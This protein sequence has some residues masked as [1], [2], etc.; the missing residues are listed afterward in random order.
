MKIRKKIVKIGRSY[1]FIID[2]VLLKNLRLVYGDEI[3]VEITKCYKKKKWHQEYILGV[4]KQ[5]EKWV[6][7]IL[8][9]NIQKRQEWKWT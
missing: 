9:K 6:Y 1:G 5:E 7:H 8:G 3:E 4:I 2:Q